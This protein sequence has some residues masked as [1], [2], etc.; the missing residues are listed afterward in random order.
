ME[1]AFTHGIKI[2]KSL[3]IMAQDEVRQRSVINDK[4]LKIH[5][6]NACKVILG[7]QKCEKEA[8][9]QFDMHKMIT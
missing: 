6:R 4:I 5:H 1:E 8:K 9:N 7:W 3:S 2:I